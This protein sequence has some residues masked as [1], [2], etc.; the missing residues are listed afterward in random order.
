MAKKIVMPYRRKREGLTDYR[1]RLVLLKSGLFRLVIRGSN[2]GVTA[3][4]VSYDADG[5]K[6]LATA[7]VKGLAALGWKGATGNSAAA[8]CTGLLLAHKVKTLKLDVGDVIVDIGLQH[9]HKGGR[10]YAVAKGAID[11]G[12][13]VRV[14]EE[15]LPSDERIQ[16]AHLNDTVKAQVAAVKT[17]LK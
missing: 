17:K 9:H 2:K 3:Q 14:G 4:L 1:K 15:T 6:V 5:D 13:N 16:G 10:L 12:L 8:Y 11:G 7:T